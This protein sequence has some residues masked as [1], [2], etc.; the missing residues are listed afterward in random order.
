M[1]IRHGWVVLC[2]MLGVA[3]GP[4]LAAAEEY[5]L[6]P[7][8]VVSIS[9]YLHP[10]LE[11]TSAIDLDGTL[12]VPPIGSIKAIGLT[13]RQLGDRISEKLS[14]YLRQTTAVTVTVTQFLSRSVFVSGAVAKPG[15]YGF[16]RIPS[17]IDVISQAGGAVPGADLSRIE[18]LRR[19]EGGRRTLRA[20]VASSLRDGV[21]VPLPDL[22]PGDTV[23]VPLTPGG[24][25]AA[26]DGAGVLGEVAKPGLYA[27][28]G[29]QDLWTVLAAAGGHT[30]RGDLS[31][32][33][34]LTYDGGNVAVITINLR[35]TLQRGG[36]GPYVVKAGD[37]VFV[38][39][40]G[41]SQFGRALTG[42]QTL[43]TVSRDVIQLAVLRELLDQQAKP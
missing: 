37:V 13:P 40:T 8:D 11:R 15:R 7:E 31:N 14:T 21:G 41:A 28:G 42:L 9:V 4:E 35:Q 25:A 30:V 36:R 19:E 10:E 23:V 12:T 33:R 39:A 34:V 32:V 29:G 22:K 26:G 24:L 2:A 18:I 38:S 5:V 6:G 43:L 20:D 27:V 17:L 1:R 16:E 3:A